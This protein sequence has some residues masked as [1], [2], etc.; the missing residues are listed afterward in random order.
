M[1]N[2]SDAMKKHQAEQAAKAAAGGPEP[3]PAE[4]AAQ[5]EPTP[6]PQRRHRHSRVILNGYSPKLVAHHKRGS[7]LAEEY[8]ELRTSLLAQ[9]KDERFCLLVTSAKPEEGKTVTCLNLGIVLAERQE[10][11]T[12]VVDCDLRWR[13]GKKGKKGKIASL[14]RSEQ[15]PG[16]ADLLRGTATLEDVLQPTSYPNLLVVPAGQAETEEVGELLAKQELEEIVGQLRRD[17]DH[18]LLDTP[19]VNVVSD[20]GIIGRAVREALLVVRMYGTDRESVD[21]AIRLLHSANVKPVGVILTH[22]QKS[23]TRYSRY[24]GYS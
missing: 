2:V 10:Y 12:A 5:P 24:G 1:G 13:K 11:R 14:L 18:V 16:M 17:F 4:D 22:H 9:Y 23:R 7:P 21:E 19:P 8:R 15:G 3:A 6:E 20:A